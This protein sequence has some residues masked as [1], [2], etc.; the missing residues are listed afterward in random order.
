[1]K[2]ELFVILAVTLAAVFALSAGAIIPFPGTVI[3]SVTQDGEP[4]AGAELELYRVGRYG[5]EDTFLGKFAAD[6]NG[7]ITAGHL[8]TGEYC[9]Q[10]SSR[11]VREEFRVT[12]A[13]FVRT[14]IDLPA[15]VSRTITVDGADITITADLSGGY[16]GEINDYGTLY[17]YE[18]T[19]AETQVCNGYVMDREEYET[20]VEECRGYDAFEE[21]DGR[22]AAFMDGGYGNYTYLFPAA[23]DVYYMLVIDNVTD[24]E[25]VAAR[26]TVSG[27]D[28]GV[29]G[30][31]YL[32]TWVVGRCALTVEKGAEENAYLVRVIW[33]NTAAEVSEW[34]YACVFDGESLTCSDQGVR[35]NVTFGE[36]GEIAESETVFENG[37]ASLTIGEDGMLTWIDSE[38]DPDLG[39]TVLEKT[40]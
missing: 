35:R 12:G 21:R 22:I 8:T 13:G 24:A 25:A 1:M 18:D 3:L 5:Q 29:K 11:V 39:A 28:D 2:R 33:G 30:D 32:G 6:A 14:A 34:E 20:R 10:D 36:D 16:L 19:G 26:V 9:W 4:L 37:A 23:R 38:A 27:P 40:A 17:L 7:R 15:S 31:D